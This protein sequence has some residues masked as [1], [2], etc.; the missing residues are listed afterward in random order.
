MP[1]IN[2]AVACSH[3]TSP[4]FKDKWCR[5]PGLSAGYSVSKSSWS[6]W[7]D[8]EVG[9]AAEHVLSLSTRA[10][11]GSHHKP[12]QSGVR[13]GVGLQQRLF[14]PCISPWKS[15]ASRGGSTVLLAGMPEYLCSQRSLA[16]TLPSRWGSCL[17]GTIQPFLWTGISNFITFKPSS[18]GKS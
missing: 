9:T 13:L 2:N 16:G 3:K 17:R 5:I 4:G 11:S 12:R 1:F 8:G 10:A 14:C 6:D 7:A 18:R 15:W